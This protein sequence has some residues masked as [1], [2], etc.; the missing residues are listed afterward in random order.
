MRVVQAVEVR[1]RD[2][3]VAVAGAVVVL[4]TTAAAAVVKLRAGRYRV[5]ATKPGFRAA[6]VTLVAR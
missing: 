1:C 6:I 2:L 4:A 5:K 3:G